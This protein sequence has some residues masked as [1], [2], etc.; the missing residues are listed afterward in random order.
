[1]HTDAVAMGGAMCN[2]LPWEL[3]YEHG[4]GVPHHSAVSFQEAVTQVAYSG[5]VP[6]SY[7]FCEKDLI[8]SPEKQRAQIKTIEESGKSVSVVSLDAGHCPIWSMPGR[9][10][11]VLVGEVE[12]GN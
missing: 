3:A 2:D 7:L 5:D 9:L 12:K 11:E 4:L 6:V 1:M 8:V 10:A